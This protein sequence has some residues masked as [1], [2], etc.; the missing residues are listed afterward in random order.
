M[1][2]YPVECVKTMVKIAKRTEPEVNYWKRFDEN[3]TIELKD[4]EDNIAYSTCITAK[5]MKADAIVCYTNTGNSARKLSGMGPG[6]PI[7]AVTNNRRTFHQLALAGNVTPILI[8]DENNIDKIIEKGI[9][10]LK[11][12]GI[13]ETGDSVIISGGK[14]IVNGVPESKQIGGYVKI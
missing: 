7:L 3:K 14:N 4:L 12:Q 13:L 11:T 6:C 9:E 2:D 10:K 1:G 8:K 5:N